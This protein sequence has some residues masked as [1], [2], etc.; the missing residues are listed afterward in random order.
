M[1]QRLRRGEKNTQKNYTKKAKPIQY[2]KVT[3]FKLK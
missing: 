2:C 3:N 1:K